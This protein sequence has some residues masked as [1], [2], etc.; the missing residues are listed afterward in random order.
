MLHIV[1][2]GHSEKV[3]FPI[4][5]KW[6]TS[7]AT[8]LRTLF[9]EEN[10]SCLDIVGFLDKRF[11]KLGFDPAFNLEVV[12]DEE[13]P[14]R[15]GE[16]VPSE[17]VIRIRETIYLKALAGDGFARQ[18]MA[19]ELWHYLWHNSETI[20]YAYVD[21]SSHIPD[22]M[23]PE[24]QADVFAAELL[25]PSHEVRGMKIHRISSIY[26]VTKKTASVQK[27]IGER[28]AAHRKSTKQITPKKQISSRIKK[29][30]S[31]RQPN[32]RRRK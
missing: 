1:H 2:K 6:I 22:E 27:Q 12:A 18:V 14:G 20:S 26:G 28:A 15:F 31:G 25:A 10:Q 21:D 23:N 29:K 8:M 24:K 32:R 16:T 7:I 17:H 4:K 19:H 30:R 5:R 11:A 9:L 3:T 13:L